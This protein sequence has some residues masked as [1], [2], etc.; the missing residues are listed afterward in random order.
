MAS[1]SREFKQYQISSS[2]RRP[3]GTGPVVKRPSL[4]DLIVRV[5]PRRT[6]N[7]LRYDAAPFVEIDG[8]VDLRFRFLPKARN[9]PLGR[10][11]LLAGP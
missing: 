7:F 9:L 2:H 8:P 4:S 5:E 3:A 6:R 10:N 11:S 1:P